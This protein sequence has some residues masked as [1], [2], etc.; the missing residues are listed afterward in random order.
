MIDKKTSLEFVITNFK[1]NNLSVEKTI[2]LI[3]M[4]YNPKTT[5]AEFQAEIRKV[6]EK[7]T[8]KMASQNLEKEWSKGC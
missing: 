6:S 4:L 1:E 7:A 5:L 8:A 3:E 2:E